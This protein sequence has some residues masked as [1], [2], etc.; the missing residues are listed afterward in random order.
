VFFH[1][2]IE[3][4]FRLFGLFL[5]PGFRLVVGDAGVTCRVKA[6]AF[7]DTGRAFAGIVLVVRI[8]GRLALVEF[9]AALL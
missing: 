8:A 4:I 3:E 7:G 1:Q 9:M 2:F 5:N 6:R